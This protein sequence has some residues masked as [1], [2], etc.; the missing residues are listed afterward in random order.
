MFQNCQKD[1]DL[2]T[3]KISSQTS[4]KRVSL[5]QVLKLKPIIESI[6]NISPIASNVDLRP[7]ETFLGLDNVITDNII[8]ITDNNNVSTYTF[9]IDT[10]YKTTGYIEN[11]HLIETGSNYIAY[12]I[13]YIPDYNWFNNLDNYTPEGDLVLDLSTFQGD[14]IKYSLEREVI[15]TTIPVDTARGGWIEV[16]TFSSVATCDYGTSIHDRGPRCGGSLGTRLVKSCSSAYTGSGSGWGN[17]GGDDTSNGGGYASN[18]NCEEVTGTLIQDSQP[19]SG[20]DTGCAVNNVTGVI[21]IGVLDCISLQQVAETLVLDPILAS[22]L[23]EPNKCAAVGQLYDYLEANPSETAFAKAAA[24]AICEGEDVDF[25]DQIIN[26]LEEK[27]LCVY[28]KLKALSFSFK[29]S[30]K[31]FDGEFPVV[32]LKFEA[33]ATMSSNTKKAYT[34]PPENYVI[35]IVLNGNPLKEASYQKRPNLLVAKTIIHEVIHAEMFRKLLS[36]SNVNGEID[37]LVLYEMVQ[38]GD[39]PGILD[40]YTRFGINGFQHQQMAEHYREKIARILQEYDSGI[41]VADDIQPDQLYLD[42]AWEGLIYSNIIAWQEI[43]DDTE[44]SRIEG[45]IEDYI[46]ENSNETCVD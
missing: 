43:M 18:N 13:R 31:K 38:N 32:H 2:L 27:A 14:K 3:T 34:R 15:W 16:C 10:N 37:P 25:E 46:T 9:T 8:Q 24:Q 1:D 39:Y 29:N 41:N 23:Q 21:A 42:L 22:C 40:Y 6:K 11:L 28:N 17:E 5:N 4:Y 12:I 35:D 26:E 36:L 33:D 7:G 20:V 19:I 30:I 45:V 44:R